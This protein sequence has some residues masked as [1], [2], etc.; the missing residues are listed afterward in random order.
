M[1]H[2]LSNKCVP[3]SV[4]YPVSVIAGAIAVLSLTVFFAA[5]NAAP[6]PPADSVVFA[7]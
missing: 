2:V 1:V 6:K 3:R 7:G 5:A 4:V